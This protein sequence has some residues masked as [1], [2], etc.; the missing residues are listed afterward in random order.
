MKSVNVRINK[1]NQATT[2]FGF[3]VNGKEELKKIAGRIR[4]VDGVI[5]VRRAG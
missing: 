5:E 2:V 4:S 3:E 1:K